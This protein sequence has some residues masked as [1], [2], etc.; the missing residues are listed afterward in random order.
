MKKSNYLICFFL[1]AALYCDAQSA[2]PD[3]E[4]LGEV[5]YYD[6]A[7]NKLVRLEKTIAKSENK[8]KMGG[9]GGMKMVYK[10]EGEKSPVRIPSSDKISFVLSTGG[11]NSAMGM[12]DPSQTLS[13]YKLDVTKGNREAVTQSYGGMYGIGKTKES[14][15]L[16]VGVKKIKDGEY[17]IIADKPLGPGEYAFVMMNMG[18]Q[19]GSFTLYAFGIN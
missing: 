16:T 12:M 15:K 17:E 7:N 13:L 5:E 19:D 10:V 18:S 4:F 14:A 2:I 9:M 3:P 8:T 11:G 1:A 6:K